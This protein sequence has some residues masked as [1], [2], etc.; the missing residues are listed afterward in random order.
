MHETA[1]T[2]LLGRDVNTHVGPHWGPNPEKM[3]MNENF[4]TDYDEYNMKE[5]TAN[6]YIRKGRIEII[7]T[8]MQ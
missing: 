7:N 3:I 2:S 8:W 5:I 6:K 1:S 4:V